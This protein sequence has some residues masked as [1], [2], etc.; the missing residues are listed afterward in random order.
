MK[1]TIDQM[2]K[3]LEQHNFSLP[4]GERKSDSVEM[5]KDRDERCHALKDSC[6]KLHAFIIDSGA[7]NHMVAS[8]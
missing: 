3:L 1:K 7:S 5:T 8:I 4:E 2:E 6:S